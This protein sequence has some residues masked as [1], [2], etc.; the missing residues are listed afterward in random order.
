[1][2]KF[3]LYIIVF[4]LM[5]VSTFNSFAQKHSYFYNQKNSFAIRA[6]INPRLIP[7]SNNR[8]DALDGG[9]YFQG[10]DKN[11]KR[12]R[13]DEKVN[14]MLN[15]SYGR[16]FGGNKIIG[17]EFN[18]QKHHLTVNR[19]L[20]VDNDN[21]DPD[22]YEKKG[23]PFLSSSPIFNVYDI[24]VFFGHF[25]K[26]A[27]APSQHLFQYGFGVRMSSLNTKQNYRMDANT[28]ITDLSKFVEGPDD[29]YLSLRFTF[30][31]TY[32]I[33]LTKNLNLDLGLSTCVGLSLVQGGLYTFNENEPIY[34]KYYI[35]TRLK[36]ENFMN[37]LYFR[38]GLSFDF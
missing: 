21:I 15:L 1:M 38:S 28:P 13:G 8:G 33:L 34:N 37:I 30:S 11:N 14:L 5:L 16:L 35:E 24:N 22:S 6:S 19:K 9:T 18:Y 7:M 32:R 25:K 4:Q 23:I 27:L 26:S 2:S 3:T 29:N 31:Y 12:V 17:A 10:Y 20:F 36:F